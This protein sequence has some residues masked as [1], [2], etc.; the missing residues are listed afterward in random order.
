MDGQ[1]A[2]KEKR[3]KSELLRDNSTNLVWFA[4]V[5]IAALGI[6]L[7]WWL[8]EP[9]CPTTIEIATGSPS[10]QYHACAEQYREILR[11]AV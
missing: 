5:G 3:T 10:G 9:P 8:L 1:R 11:V 2:Q 7:A 6:S 4:A